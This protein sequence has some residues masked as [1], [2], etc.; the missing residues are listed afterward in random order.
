[1]K[2]SDVIP[3]LLMLAL[4]AAMALET[5]SLGYWADTTPGPAFLPVWLAI[6]GTLLVALRILEA[7]KS[8]RR[9]VWPPPA[10]LIRVAVIVAGLAG[11]PLLAPLLGLVP[12]LALFIAFLLLAVLR[13]PFWPSLAALAITMG[14]V[15]GIFVGWLGVPVPKGLL[16][17]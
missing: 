14:L 6:A 1:L 13:Q 12:S 5:R 7:R 16:G 15:Y 17:I 3:A 10:A 8:P 4:S 9:T 11:V 2:P